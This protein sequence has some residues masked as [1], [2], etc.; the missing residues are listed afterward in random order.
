MTNQTR[1]LQELGLNLQKITKR[2]LSNQNLLRYLSYT[3]KD[4]LSTDKPD[5]SKEEAYKDGATGVVR[6][7]P[8]ISDKEDSSSILTLRVLKG[9]PSI[10]NSEFLEIY[11]AIEI[12]VPLK[13]WVIKDANL[14]T[15]AIMGEVQRSLEGKR[16]NGLGEIR[17][18]GF[19]ANFFTEEMSA[20]TMSFS[21]LQFN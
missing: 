6:V 17:G 3:D 21:I 16:I 4:P 20:Y 2:L 14:R 9:V 5:I 18:S 13:Q 11:F 7:V 12:F 19:S 10:E 15:Y 1:F 8:L